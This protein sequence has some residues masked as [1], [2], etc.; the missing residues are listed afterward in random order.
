MG[1][2]LGV[3]LQT[4]HY[5]IYTSTQSRDLADRLPEFMESALDHYTTALVSLPKPSQLMTSYLFRNRDQWGDYTRQRLP[6]EANTYLKLGRGGYTTGGETVYYDIGRYDTF[7][8]AAHEGW[9]QFTQNTFK[10]MLPI[11]LEEGVATY[12]EGNSMRGGTIEF[13]PWRNFERYRALRNA[14]RD[15]G[16]IPLT[17]LINGTPQSFLNDGGKTPLLSY[18]AQVWALVH[19]LNEG[20]GGK[21]REGL[22][23]V[24]SDA[25]NGRLAGVLATSTKISTTRQRH[26]ALSSRTGPWVLLAY[27]NQNLDEIEREFDAFVQEIT[28]R[29]NEN[30]IRGGQSPLLKAESTGSR[31]TA[32]AATHDGR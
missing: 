28:D 22:R 31:T 27:F 20:E 8:I 30:A 16:L 2:I 26:L 5:Q 11:W 12:M 25:A 23:K 15:G 19:F 9:H 29:S 21:Y 10:H 14:V 4:P 17:R 24:I 6:N 32:A 7:I 18:Y 3:R 1:E 13:L